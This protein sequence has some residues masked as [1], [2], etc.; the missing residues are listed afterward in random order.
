LSGS[1]FSTLKN[2]GTNDPRGPENITTLGEPLNQYD[3][4][5]W[6]KTLLFR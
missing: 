4:D 3:I 2:H 5:F 6:L 1:P